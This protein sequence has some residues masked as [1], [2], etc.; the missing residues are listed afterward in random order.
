M[1]R[2]RRALQQR[3]GAMGARPHRHAGP[4]DHHR[5]VMGVDALQLEGDDGALAR[6]VP[7][8]RSEL[9]SRSRSWA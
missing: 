3:L 4:V 7:K 2:S 1:S 6:R 9:I 8:M 5:H